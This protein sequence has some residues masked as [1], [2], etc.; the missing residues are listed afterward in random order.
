LNSPQAEAEWIVGK[1]LSMR[2]V[3]FTEEGHSR[4]LTWSDCAILLRCV[5]NSAGPVV[6]ALRRANIPYVIKG[7]AGLFDA[8]EVLAA[9]A[10]V[11]YLNGEITGDE[12][13]KAWQAANLGIEDAKLQRAIGWLDAEK[14]DWPN[15]LIN[16]TYSIQQTFQGFLGVIELREDTIPGRG[17]HDRNR[18]ELVYY[19]LGKFSQ[20]IT[21]FEEIHWQ[22]SAESLYAA[23]AG[24][25]RHQAA[26]YYPE[27]WE[28]A[29]FVT[30]DAVQIMTIHQA[31]G[32]E[33]PVVFLPNLVKNRFPTPSAR[34]RQWWHVIPPT[35]VKGAERYLGSV[36]DERRLFYVALTRSKKHLYCTWAPEATSG[37]YSRQSSF[38]SEFTASEFVLTREPSPSSIAKIEPKAAKADIEIP[39]TFAELK[40]YFQCPYQFKLRYMY[41]FNPGFHEKLG[42]GKSLHDCLA[43]VH[44]RALDGKYLKPDDVPRLL[45]DHLHL[46]Y[47]WPKLLVDMRT[48]AD[49]V[50]RKYLRENSDVLDKIEFA[51]KT[52]ELKLAEGIV[53]HGRIDLIR[54]T[55]TKQVIIIDFK[56]TDRAQEEDV[57]S[58]Q[59]HIY[60]MGYQQLAGRSADLV[61]IYSLDKGA[62]AAVRELVD[63]KLLKKNGV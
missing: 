60:A 29:A 30:P 12:L 58:T 14:A 28:D 7:G 44:R 53:V 45:D 19:N 55:D 4:G 34:G 26:D 32:M 3:P 46:P 41:G 13:R 40:Y 35:A 42:Y 24:F 5:K 23:F 27:G 63:E 17:V 49:I 25:L 6:D 51:E 39:L 2:G 20:V 10:I 37:H 50:M 47:A 8:A 11:Y 56:S 22:S 57:T 33:F 38:V 9:R 15:R 62:G 43:E 21:D 18:G 1:V 52:V 59:L 36:E 48:Q 31:K 54:R 16:R 61:E